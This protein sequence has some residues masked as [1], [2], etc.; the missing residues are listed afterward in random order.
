MSK[1]A[2]NYLLVKTDLGQ[3]KKGFHELPAGDH[4]YGKAP[5][6]DKFG[7]REGTD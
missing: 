7:A 5:T 2:E 4:T 3:V 6:K 1:K